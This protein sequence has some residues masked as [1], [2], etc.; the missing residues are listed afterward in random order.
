MKTLVCEMCGGNN[1]LKQEGVYVCQNCKTQYS[2]EEAKKMM[3]E[4]TVDV[5][6][7]TVKVDN[8]AKLDNLYKVARMARD[9]GNTAQAFKHYEQLQLEDPDSWEPAFFVPYYSA[10]NTLKN[11]Q[12]GDSVRVS[13]GRVSLGC[14]YRSGISPAISTIS[15]CL[16]SVF[17]L[18]EEIQDY[19]EQD[20]AIN[21]V[22]QYVMSIS[23]GLDDIIDNEHSRMQREILSFGRQTES[24]HFE[25]VRYRNQDDALAKSYRSDVSGMR[26]DADRRIRRIEEAIAKRRFDEFWTANQPLK[27][28]LEAEKE[29]LLGQIAN[30]NTE[31]AEIPA[32]TEGYAELLSLQDQAER[33]KADKKNL[34]MLKF[35]DK[36]AVQEQIDYTNNQMVP[37]LS[38][39]DAA[40]AVVRE[41]IF[42]L[43][44][45]VDEIDTELTRPR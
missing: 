19:D 34:G 24:G 28:Q 38:R 36:K 5:T 30:Y 26:S 17:D 6:G 3:I 18:I 1:L 32:R 12:P 31:I 42:P 13:G 33:L 20:T 35:K 2:V 41:R 14:N 44:N 8:S 29:P 45:R 25:I 27:A 21:T 23:T 7:S 40:I 37:I 15:N 22:S 10:I 4:G 39:I 9:D 43:Q 11:D 16:D